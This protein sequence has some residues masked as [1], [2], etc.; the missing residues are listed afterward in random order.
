[1][2]HLRT[3]K[4]TL[5]VPSKLRGPI[6]AI[7]AGLLLTLEIFQVPLYSVLSGIDIAVQSSGSRPSLPVENFIPLVNLV[8]MVW[9]GAL[10]VLEAPNMGTAQRGCL[11]L[12]SIVGA[13]L[14]G[15]EAGYFFSLNE[16]ALWYNRLDGM[17]VRV[18]LGV[19]AFLHSLLAIAWLAWFAAFY[20][21]CGN[22]I[23]HQQARGAAWALSIAMAC[24]LIPSQQLNS[25]APLVLGLTALLFATAQAARMT[26]QRGE[27]PTSD[28]LSLAL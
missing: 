12:S 24:G 7:A 16:L 6:F 14:V 9:A 28:A 8:L 26:T 10:L 18:P 22:A 15:L 3:S 5:P 17:S 20:R 19:V 4:L 25:P 11:L 27:A 2:Q 13:S 23:S 21:R 1:M